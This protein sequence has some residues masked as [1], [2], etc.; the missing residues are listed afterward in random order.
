MKNDK[1]VKEKIEERRI[2]NDL[3]RFAVN[4]LKKFPGTFD[5]DDLFKMLLG[6]TDFHQDLYTKPSV[7]ELITSK[8]NKSN[9]VVVIP[10]ETKKRRWR[11]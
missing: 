5:V 9:D 8:L 3:L 6:A 1:R 11:K 2:K 4:H 10:E 7:L